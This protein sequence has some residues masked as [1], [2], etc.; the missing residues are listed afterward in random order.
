MDSEKTIEKKLNDEV[1]KLDGWSL[2]LPC[3]YVSGLPDR[4]VLLPKGV[5][6][7]VEVKTTG[8]KPTAIQKL[9]HEKIRKLGF[10][11]YVIDSLKLLYTILNKYLT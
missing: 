2:K 4:L 9:V 11:V 10:D 6:F 8:K 7:F 3:V 1:S 5:V